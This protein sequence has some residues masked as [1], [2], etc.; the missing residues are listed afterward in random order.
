MNQTLKQVLFW[1]PRVLG[2]L[3][4]LF[5]SVFALDVFDQGSG[6]W[7]TLVALAMHLI[8]TL[9]VLVVLF[10]AWR[11]EWVGG[12]LFV[13]LGVLYLTLVWEPSNLPAYLFIS[14][15]L[16]L[17]GLLFLLNGCFRSALRSNT[18]SQDRN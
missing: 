2:L 16:F 14:G 6:F 11:W 10:I 1:S 18:H 17:V 7:E 15:P 5:V 9:V 12:I 3:V 8:P 4:A 13:M